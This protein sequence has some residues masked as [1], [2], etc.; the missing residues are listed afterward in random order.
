MKWKVLYHHLVLEQDKKEIDPYNWGIIVNTI[1]SKLTTEPGYYGKHL[2]GKLK[3]FYKLPINKYR[4]IYQIQED[5]ILVWIVKI[6]P[7]KNDKVYIDFLTR[8]EKL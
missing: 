1:D 8:K 3:G 7:R 2:H 5:K 4:V 6:G